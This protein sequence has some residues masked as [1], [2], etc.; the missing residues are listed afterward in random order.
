[1]SGKMGLGTISQAVSNE[2]HTHTQHRLSFP[3]FPKKET[4]QP[5]IHS[6]ITLHVHTAA[7]RIQKLQETHFCF[8]DEQMQEGT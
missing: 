5:R 3:S 2:T 7:L 8:A 1:M 4:V 6:S